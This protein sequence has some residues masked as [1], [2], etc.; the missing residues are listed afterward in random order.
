MGPAFPILS[1]DELTSGQV[2][3][4]LGG[5][6]TADLRRV[7]EYELRHA[8]RKSVLNSIDKALS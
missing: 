6:S 3:K 4:R 1:Y 8:N 5:L 2:Q 7:R